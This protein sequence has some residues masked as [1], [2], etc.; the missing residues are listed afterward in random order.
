MGLYSKKKKKKKGLAQLIESMSGGVGGCRSC[1]ST[2]TIWGGDM[3]LYSALRKEK[4]WTVYLEC[5]R[6][7]GL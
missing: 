4:V 7:L 1:Q 3:V 6:A 2:H 5:H